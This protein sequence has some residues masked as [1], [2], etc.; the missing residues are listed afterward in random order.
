[1]LG[2]GLAQLIITIFWPAANVRKKLIEIK[3]KIKEFN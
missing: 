2:V 3:E 1:M